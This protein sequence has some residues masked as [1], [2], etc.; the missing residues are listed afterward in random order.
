MVPKTADSMRASHSRNV[1]LLEKHGVP[2]IYSD[3]YGS[4][5]IH[6]TRP[7]NY[8]SGEHFLTTED[9]ATLTLVSDFIISCLDC[10]RPNYHQ[11]I[12]KR[13]VR[14]IFPDMSYV[15]TQPHSF[16]STLKE[17]RDYLCKTYCINMQA[18]S[19]KVNCL[20]PEKR[21]VE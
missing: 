4:G 10:C 19:H 14:A 13:A 8:V 18:P 17:R 7:Y 1:L 20:L 21:H 11:M 5:I 3:L 6:L 9:T 12:Q 16:L 2:Y 15:Y